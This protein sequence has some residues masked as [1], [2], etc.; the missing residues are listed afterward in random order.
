MRHRQGCTTA[1]RRRDRG[2]WIAVPSVLSTATSARDLHSPAAERPGAPSADAPKR[3][4]ARN[5][6]AQPQ[7]LTSPAPRS[8]RAAA[9]ILS[10]YI[11]RR[12]YRRVSTQRHCP[13]ST[14]RDLG[15]DPHSPS[16]GAHS[17]ASVSLDLQTLARGRWVGARRSSGAPLVAAARTSRRPTW[18]H[19]KQSERSSTLDTWG[20]IPPS[21]IS[22]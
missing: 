11:I 20:S 5:S 2:N 19:W 22:G 21:V 7:S 8:V 16:E 9:R 4:F 6:V 15:R 18:L 1:K 3:P 10:S 12:P 13:A 14:G 17:I